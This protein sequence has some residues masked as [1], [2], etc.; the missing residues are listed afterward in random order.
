MREG[1]RTPARL[2]SPAPSCAARRA[3]KPDEGVL[4]CVQDEGIRAGG[5]LRRRQRR[6]PGGECRGWRWGGLLASG[7]QAG[8]AARRGAVWLTWIVT[9]TVAR[10]IFR[11]CGDEAVRDYPLLTAGG[12]VM[13]AT[14][15][16]MTCVRLLALCD[17]Y[18][19]GEAVGVCAAGV[20]AGQRRRQQ[21]CRRG[22][23]LSA[24]GA[25]SSE[26]ASECATVTRAPGGPEP[27]RKAV[28]PAR[29]M[30]AVTLVEHPEPSAGPWSR[31]TR[32]TSADRAREAWKWPPTRM[33]SC[34]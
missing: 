31:R 10:R 13:L 4:V 12:I 19:F 6:R 14:V 28:P 21:R 32:K 29:N 16:A 20:A 2:N 24:D 26:L 5:G 15:M 3:P 33:R 18:L 8:Q 25:S 9:P 1:G 34:A 7:A 23:R 27:M 11:T 22:R 30:C 17:G